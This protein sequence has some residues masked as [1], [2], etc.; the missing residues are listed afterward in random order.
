V[1]EPDRLA[2]AGPLLAAVG[3]YFPAV[4]CRV[5]RTGPAGS[6]LADPFAPAV[7]PPAAPVRKD[8]QPQVVAEEEMTSEE[9]HI[10]PSAL[11]TRE[12][13]AMLL[14]PFDEPAGDEAPVDQPVA[15]G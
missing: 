3:R 13:L 2:A 15:A 10:D 11:L 9:P 14:S 12:E 7:E 1:V 6:R 8:D 4:A 5:C